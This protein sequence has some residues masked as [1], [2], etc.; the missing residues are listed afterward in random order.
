MI[1]QPSQYLYGD[2]AQ[3]FASSLSR[4]LYGFIP[5]AAQRGKPGWNIFKQ[6]RAIQLTEVFNTNLLF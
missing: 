4:Q 5:A 3:Q 2:L 6:V 1:A